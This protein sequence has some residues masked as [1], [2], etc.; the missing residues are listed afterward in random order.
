MAD[1]ALRCRVCEAEH[2]LAI[3]APSDGNRAVTTARASGGG[4]HAVPIVGERAAAA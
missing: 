4:I 3:G 1:A 2:M